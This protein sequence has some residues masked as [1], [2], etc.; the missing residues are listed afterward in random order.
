MNIIYLTTEELSYRLKYDSRYIREHLKD[1][2]LKKDIHYI[3]PFGGR[4]ILF[5]WNEIEKI[6]T[7]PYKED[8]P[9]E[10]IKLRRRNR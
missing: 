10:N 2:V 9:M 6:L 8:N 5:I 1:K 4:K 3:K 7:I